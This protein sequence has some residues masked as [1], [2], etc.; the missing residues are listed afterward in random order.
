MKIS[1]TIN[2]YNVN[3]D[4][5]ALKYTGDRAFLSIF[6]AESSLKNYDDYKKMYLGVG[7]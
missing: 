4:P 6:E 1:A 5:E 2:F 7:Q 3:S